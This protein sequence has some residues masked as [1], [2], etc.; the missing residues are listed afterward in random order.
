MA[1]ILKIPIILIAHVAKIKDD[2]IPD[3][4]DIR[5]SSFITQEA[6]VVLMMY[7]VKNKDTAK[8]ITDDLT[9]ET[10][11]QKAILSVELDR[12]Q[13][14]TGKIALWHNGVGFE[15]FVNGVHDILMDVKYVQN[16]QQG[17]LEGGKPGTSKNAM[18]GTNR[19][20]YPKLP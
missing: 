9:I 10:Y 1:V 13:G 12:V 11:T 3:W 20:L 14:R 5:D 18:G 6:D 15:K 8:K 4:T 19:E 7:R 16:K 2:K 17:N